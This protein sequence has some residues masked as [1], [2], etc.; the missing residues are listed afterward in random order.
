M[1]ET[2]RDYLKRRVSLVKPVALGGLGLAFVLLLRMHGQ[3][4]RPAPGDARV[5]LAVLAII[6]TVIAVQLWSQ[7]RLKCPRCG[8]SLSKLALI[9]AYVPSKALACPHCAVSFDEPYSR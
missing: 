7:S 8:K 3:V 6:A 4:S 5:A 2:I 9:L 1:S